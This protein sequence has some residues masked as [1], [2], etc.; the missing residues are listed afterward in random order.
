MKKWMNSWPMGD[1]PGSSGDAPAEAT[2]PV[3]AAPPP[4]AAPEFSPYVLDVKDAKVDKGMLDQ[5]T[6]LANEMKI[7]KDAAERIVGIQIESVKAAEKAAAD[8]YEKLYASWDKELKAIPNVEASIASVKSE[9][10]KHFDPETQ[11]MFLEG[12]LLKHPGLVK[13]LSAIA[14]LIGPDSMPE[15]TRRTVSQESKPASLG[16]QMFPGLK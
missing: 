11:K 10:L 8:H 5:F 16:E 7:P 12:D 9:V 6:K 13:G 1:E 4:P 2:P 3:P 15:G 14:K